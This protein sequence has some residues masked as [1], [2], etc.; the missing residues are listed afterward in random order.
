M[1]RTSGPAAPATLSLLVDGFARGQWRVTEADGTATMHL[2]TFVPLTRDERAEVEAEAAGVLEMRAP[3]S[4]Q[5][6]RSR[7]AREL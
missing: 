5:E 6:L 3:G 1:T 2:E 7:Q 4:A